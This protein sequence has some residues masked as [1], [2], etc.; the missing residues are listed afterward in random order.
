[1]LNRRIFENVLS[2][3]YVGDPID[4]LLV[5]ALNFCLLEKSPFNHDRSEGSL[6]DV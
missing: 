6:L 2:W 4:T 5:N 3:N 1:M